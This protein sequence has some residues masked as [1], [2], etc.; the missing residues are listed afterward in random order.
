MIMRLNET[1]RRLD[2]VEYPLSVDNL[3]LALEDPTIELASGSQ[4]LSAVFRTVNIDIVA[5][6]DEAKLMLLSGLASE[7]IGR[8]YYSDRDPPTAMER[9]VEPLTF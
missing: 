3:V 6:P 4:Q 8:K 9:N 1:L 2:A 7:A 5:D